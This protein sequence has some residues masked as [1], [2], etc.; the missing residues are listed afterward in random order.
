MHALRLLP[1]LTLLLASISTLSPA[2]LAAPSGKDRADAR[3]L[4]TDGRKAMKDKRW[5]DAVVALKKAERLDPTPALS[6]ELAQAQVAAGKL[7]EAQRTL[8]SVA[9]AAGGADLV[10]K[11]AKKALDDLKARVPTVKVI[12]A[13]PPAAQVSTLVDG[14]EVDGDEIPL[15]PGDHTISVE[16]KGYAPAEKD[17]H[18]AEGA[19][20]EVRLQLVARAA[21]AAEGQGQAPKGSRVPG[22]IVTSIGAA[23]VLVGGVFGGLAFKATSTA[24]AQCQGDV[25]P[26]SAGPDVSRSKTYG[27]VATGM[28]IAGGAVAVTGIVLIIAA[29][30]GGK[31][32]DAPKAASARVSPW[33]GPGGAGIGATGSF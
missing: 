15:N 29:P 31:A 12:V 4:V 30:G 20:Q 19:R 13:G 16:A 1:V 14:I 26:A 2:A 17:V 28:L 8:L 3:A 5:A 32:D 18:L 27:N 9:P 21:V 7:T 11:A 10:K 22:V 23:G 33:F 6:V 24:K 25:C